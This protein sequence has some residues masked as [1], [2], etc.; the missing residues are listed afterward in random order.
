ML[1]LIPA[2]LLAVSGFLLF[3]AL[4]GTRIDDHP[5]CRAC[6]F[7][8]SGLDGVGL[9]QSPVTCPECGTDVASPAAI[10]RGNRRRRRGRIFASGVLTAMTL[11][12]FAGALWAATTRVNWVAFLP[13]N[14]LISQVTPDGNLRDAAIGELLQRQHDGRLSPDHLGDIASR[15][16][17]IQ[18][19]PDAFWSQACGEA[20][21]VLW[22]ANAF[23]PDLRD[24]IIR[25][26]LTVDLDIRP[27]AKDRIGFILSGRI[28]RTGPS[29]LWEF[30]PLL[31]AVE[32]DGRPFDPPHP[33]A[34]NS[35]NMMGSGRISIGDAL[36]LDLPEGEHH[37]AFRWSIRASAGG[38]G[39][40][41]EE[42]FEET[43]TF[44]A[45]LGIR[46]IVDDALR[47]AIAGSIRAGRV[48][49]EDGALRGEV[50]IDGPPCPLAFSAYFDVGGQ[51]LLAGL[52]VAPAGARSAVF[53]LHAN[54]GGLTVGERTAI[55]LEPSSAVAETNPVID[56]YWGEEVRL[57]DLPIHGT[58]P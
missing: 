16:A 20:L 8:L 21:E 11:A 37:I 24:A 44:K 25:R 58:G 22:H 47:A 6:R 36:L 27:D 41:W 19:H 34:R 35:A 43:I 54:S 52:I 28:D 56:A 30:A 40:E 18:T 7:D 9:A 50:R 32:I 51:R 42:S 17:A 53:G 14:I 10:R 29:L 15:L 31:L 2:L 13:T 1:V 26:T 3:V 57:D 48:T 33:P 55:V 39:V 23:S 49:L 5:V 12:L 46:T 45:D 38:I 4:R